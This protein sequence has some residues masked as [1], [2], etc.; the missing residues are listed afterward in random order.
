MKS[1]QDIE[2]N[3]K[4]VFIRADLNVPFTDKGAIADDTRLQAAAN[5][6]NYALE[7]H[8]RVLLASHL[9][10]PKGEKD[11]KLSLQPVATALSKILNKEVRFVADCVGPEVEH[12]VENLPPGEVLLL[13]NLRFHPEEKKAELHFAEQLAKLCDVYVND[14]FATAHRAHASTV[15]M[16][17]L[18]AERVAGLTLKNEMEQLSKALES[19]QKPLV[20]II[21]GAKV[22]GKIA[23]IRHIS[24]LAD[25]VLIGGAMANT[26]FAAQ[27]HSVGKS[28]YEPEQADYAR[29]L[30]NSTSN[31][32]LPSD[33]VIATSLQAP[34]A[35][36]NVSVDA[37]PQ[38]MMAL[39]IGSESLKQFQKSIEGA[40]TVVWNGP[41]GAFE[42]PPFDTGTVAIAKALATTKAYT[43]VGGGD[44]D[45]AVHRAGVIN[46]IDYI[47]TGGGAFLAVLEGGELPAV[48]ALSS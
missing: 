6:V 16:A 31:L 11:P 38:D 42:F 28:L 26:F 29:E 14:A 22:S 34:G 33:V 18:V 36:K 13:E 39:D 37:I 47:S 40:G 21:G 15:T 43:V 46:D 8:A 5:T 12:A 1:I 17:Q 23:A 20:A 45:L 41:V 44:S 48:K 25:E 24:K 10:R 3:H 4:R 7:R 9:G 30:L 19:P 2:L 35:T 27:G 32:V